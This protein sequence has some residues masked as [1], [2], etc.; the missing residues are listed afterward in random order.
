MYK[1]APKTLE[2]DLSVS[3]TEEKDSLLELAKRGVREGFVN[4]EHP[5]FIAWMEAGNFDK[6]QGLLCYSTA[7]MQKVLVSFVDYLI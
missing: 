6:T 2:F 3:D 5:A 1:V 4:V 7:F